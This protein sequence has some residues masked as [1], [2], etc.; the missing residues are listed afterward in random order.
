MKERYITM[1]EV[2]DRIQS[3]PDVNSTNKSHTML[4]QLGLQ[5]SNKPR[6]LRQH[7]IKSRQTKPIKDILDR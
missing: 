1:D 5:E 6:K 4:L 7:I 2:V 3:H